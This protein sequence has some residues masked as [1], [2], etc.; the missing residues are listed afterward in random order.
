[1]AA[2]P[3]VK[4]KLLCIMQLKRN[5]GPLS[6]HG[7]QN[8]NHESYGGGIEISLALCALSP[9]RYSCYIYLLSHGLCSKSGEARLESL[10]SSAYFTA[11]I[12]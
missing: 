8:D 12:L 5:C 9:R 4:R 1:M 2:V 10:Y 3:G 11:L 7:G 6:K